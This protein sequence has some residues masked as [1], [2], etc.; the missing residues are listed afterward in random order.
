MSAEHLT[1]TPDEEIREVGETDTIAVLLPQAEL[2]YMTERRAN[3]RLFIE[4]EVPVAIGDR[5][6][7][8]DPRHVAGQH[9]RDRRRRGFG[10]PRPRRSSAATLN[11]AYACGCSADRGS[12][13]VGKRGDVTVLSVDHPAE[14]CL[15]VGQEVVSDVIIGGEIVHSNRQPRPARPGEEPDD[16]PRIRPF[17]TRDTYPTRSSTTISARPWW[18]ATPSTCAVRWP[19]SRH[20]G[21]GRDR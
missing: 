6:L 2:M 19:G 15:A 3:A 17:N 13:D 7:L 9:D 11:A 5:L 18:P 8:L 4:H 1:Y 10:S 12:L 20:G 21:V 16:P 14:L